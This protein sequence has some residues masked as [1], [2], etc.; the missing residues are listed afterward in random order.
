MIEELDLHALSKMTKDVRK[1]SQTL[2]TKEA[3]Y[4]VDTY[5]VFS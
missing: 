5:Y 4:L 3:R 2:G 1:S